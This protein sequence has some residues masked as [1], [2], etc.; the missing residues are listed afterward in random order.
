MEVEEVLGVH[1]LEA[2]A[3]ADD[4]A[5]RHG[6]VGTAPRGDL[7]REVVFRVVAPWGVRLNRSIR[8]WN[9]SMK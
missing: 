9:I 7:E 3:V 2:G 4:E 8:Q 6:V 1:A 5:L